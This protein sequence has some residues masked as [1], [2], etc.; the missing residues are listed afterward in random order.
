MEGHR[1]DREDTF[2]LVFFFCFFFCLDPVGN[3]LIMT[4]EAQ[5]EELEDKKLRTME[6]LF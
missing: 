3:C 6:Q 1:L 5:L 4:S 2:G